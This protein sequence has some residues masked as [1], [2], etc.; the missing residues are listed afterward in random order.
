MGE[1][2]NRERGGNADFLMVRCRYLGIWGC[3]FGGTFPI[4]LIVRIPDIVASA[5]SYRER[6]ITA[7]G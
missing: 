1:W 4:I 5:F 3:G 2:G 7:R 6:C